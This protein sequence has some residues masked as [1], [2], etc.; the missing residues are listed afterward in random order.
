MKFC[1]ISCIITFIFII[2][3]LS[4]N[5]FAMNT[6]QIYK[7][8][9]SQENNIKYNKIKH[10]RKKIALDGLYLG[11]LI[12]VIII[13]LLKNKSKRSNTN[14]LC[15]VGSITFTIQVFYYILSKK[16]DY[17]ILHLDKEKDRIQW[18]DV[19]RKYQVSYYGGLFVGIVGVTI[20]CMQFRS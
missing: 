14:L 1:T 20:I 11:L 16:S 4:V 17:M 19:Y 10:E 5:I 2:A 3:N 13:L 12:S 9:L 15:L 6:S 8:H 18:L 7:S